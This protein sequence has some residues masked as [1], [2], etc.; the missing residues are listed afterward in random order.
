MAHSRAT[1]MEC[2]GNGEFQVYKTY[3]CTIFL[4]FISQWARLAAKVCMRHEKGMN[5]EKYGKENCGREKD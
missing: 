3:S 5:R 4:S 1:M 2:L